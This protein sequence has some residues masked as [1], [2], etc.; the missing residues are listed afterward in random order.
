MVA[1]QSN[2]KYFLDTTEPFRLLDEFK[3]VEKLARKINNSG[4]KALP[5]AT[6]MD[7]RSNK[8]SVIAILVGRS[9]NGLSNDN[10]YIFTRKLQ[11]IYKSY[12]FSEV[13]NLC[14]H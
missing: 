2:I 5:L 11:H 4:R 14:L 9:D 7:F 13:E 12:I 8:C 3:N 1:M 6:A 10:A